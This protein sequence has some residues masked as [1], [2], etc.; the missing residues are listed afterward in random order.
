MKSGIILDTE[1]WIKRK[2][3]NEYLAIIKVML[4]VYIN[5]NPKPNKC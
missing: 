5:K 2:C 4:A 1:K 3:K